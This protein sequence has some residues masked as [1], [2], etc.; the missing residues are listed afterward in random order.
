M[1]QRPFCTF[2]SKQAFAGFAYDSTRL[3]T[4]SP[5]HHQQRQSA[6]CMVNNN[7]C[8]HS[9][10]SLSSLQ[11]VSKVWGVRRNMMFPSITQPLRAHVTKPSLLLHKPW[12]PVGY[13]VELLRAWIKLM[14][15]N[16]KYTYFLHW[17][18]KSITKWPHFCV[19][20]Y[21]LKGFRPNGE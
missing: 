14:N 9:C 16:K 8:L 10:E 20:R 5:E 3:K 18:T 17:Q 15:S 11:G 12:P 19:T 7:V 6:C 2:E 4:V 21:P 13:W 1:L